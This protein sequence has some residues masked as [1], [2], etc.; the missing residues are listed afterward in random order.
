[1]TQSPIAVLQHGVRQYGEL[2][3]R[4][5]DLVF[6]PIVKGLADDDLQTEVLF[7]EDLHVVAQARNPCSRRRKITL[8]DLIDQPWCL[9]ALD[10]SVGMRCVEAFRA[11]G[12]DVPRRT[13]T[14]V[15]MQLQMGLVTT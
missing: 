1:M 5:V 9:P 2:R 6:G 3:E 14:T 11:N 8:A 4:N 7:E 12:L 13:V 15:S 10:S